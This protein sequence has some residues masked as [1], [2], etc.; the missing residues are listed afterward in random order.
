MKA[1]LICLLAFTSITALASTPADSVKKTRINIRS[2]ADP[3]S[4]YYNPQRAFEV[5]TMFANKGKAD[6]MNA[7]GILYSKGIGVKVDDAQALNWFEKAAKNGYARA[8]YNLGDM[9]R[10][11]IGTD[12]DL[13]KALEAYQQGANLNDRKCIYGEGYMRYKGFGCTQSYEQAVAYFKRGVTLKDD[14][15]YFML[16]LCYRNGYGITANADSAKFWLAKAAAFQDK[17]AIRELADD[18]PENLDLQTVPNLQPPSTAQ[19][20]AVDLTTGFKTILHHVD[21]AAIAGEYTGYVIKFDW[22]GKHIISQVALKLELELN[23]TTLSGK[24]QEEGQ[25][26]FA[27]SGSLRDTAVIFNNTAFGMLDHYY[28]VKPLPI[29][30][31]NARFNLVK[32]NDTVYLSGT[33][34]LY[35]PQTKETQ[36][37]EFFMLIRTGTKTDS[38]A[39]ANQFNNTDNGLKTDSLHFL[40][41]PNPFNGGLKLRYTLKKAMHISIMVSNLLNGSIVYRST[42][43]DLQAGDYTNPISFNGAPGNYVVTLQYGSNTRSAIIFKQ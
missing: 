31:V 43:G 7:L 40:A 35:S 25:E 38:S 41:Y 15:S 18:S 13:V 39:F 26:P 33:P 4:K 17:R 12:L 8:Y 1:L 23:D 21:K 9:Y 20:P 42:P 19:A 11:G 16:G 37:A 32:I 30:F 2:F 14:G 27:I 10:L 34:R 29:S 36:K 24:W 22:S 28:K 6:A 5:Y 3:K